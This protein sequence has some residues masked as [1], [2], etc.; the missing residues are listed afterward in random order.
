[1]NGESDMERRRC[2]R[3]NVSLQAHLRIPLPEMGS[4]T[5]ILRATV[6]N[7]TLTGA[8]VFVAAIKK[9]HTPV[10]LRQRRTCSLILKIPGS[11][12]QSVF[13]SEIS[14]VDLRA[15]RTRPCAYLG[16]ELLEMSEGDRQRLNRFL[17]SLL[18]KAGQTQR[19]VRSELP[20]RDTS[21]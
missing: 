17:A 13:A 16:L 4:A 1:M 21:F 10:L 3:T 6:E 8:R 14:W 12:D 15:G 18:D 11:E 5:L 19:I 2:G 9:V 7:L 20:S